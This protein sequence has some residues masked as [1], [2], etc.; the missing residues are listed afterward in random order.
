M[1]LKCDYIIDRQFWQRKGGGDLAKSGGDLAG[2]F[3]NGISFS[4]VMT[5]IMIVC[6][7]PSRV[8]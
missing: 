5:G 6:P 2:P 7:K 1:T 8:T 3:R 4:P